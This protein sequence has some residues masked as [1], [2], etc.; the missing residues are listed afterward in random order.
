LIASVHKFLLE[1]VEHVK[2]NKERCMLLER[3]F[4][5]LKALLKIPK[6]RCTNL[7]RKD[8]CSV[9]R[10]DPTSLLITKM[11]RGFKNKIVA[12]KYVFSKI[13]RVSVGNC[14]EGIFNYI[15]L[16]IDV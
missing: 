9:T 7:E 16:Q 10:R 6:S 8:H 15:C 3:G 12:T 5:P 11:A 14:Q 13:L 1:N 4:K 2:G